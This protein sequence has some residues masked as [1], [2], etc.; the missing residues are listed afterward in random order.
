MDYGC[1]NTHSFIHC[2][3]IEDLTALATIEVLHAFRLKVHVYHK[4]L[5]FITANKW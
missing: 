5:F 3:Q 2:Q 1:S 4:F